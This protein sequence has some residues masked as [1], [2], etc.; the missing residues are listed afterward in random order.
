MASIIYKITN[1]LGQKNTEKPTYPAMAHL[2]NDK[3]ERKQKIKLYNE[4]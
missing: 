4:I 1:K 3:R 2:L